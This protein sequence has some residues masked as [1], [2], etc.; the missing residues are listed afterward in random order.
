LK[1]IQIQLLLFFTFSFEFPL[2]FYLNLPFLAIP[3]IFL[4][5]NFEVFPLLEITTFQIVHLDYLLHF[6]QKIGQFD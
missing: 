2:I 1:Q 5:S 3:N 4:T 6:D